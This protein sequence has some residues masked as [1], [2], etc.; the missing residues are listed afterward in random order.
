MRTLRLR[1]GYAVVTFTVGRLVTF[2]VR[3]VV[4]YTPSWTF[5]DLLRFPVCVVD[6]LTFTATPFAQLARLHHHAYANTT[7]VRLLRMP[8]VW[9]RIA[10][11][12]GLRVGRVVLGYYHR[13]I[14]GSTHVVT[15]TVC[16]FV[17]LRTHAHT[18]RYGSAT[19]AYV[20]LRVLPTLHR[21]V[22]FWLPVVLVLVEAHTTP[23][24]RLHTRAVCA[25]TRFADAVRLYAFTV[26]TARCVAPLRITRLVTHG[27]CL[28]TFAVWL[29]VLVTDPLYG[30]GW[31]RFIWIQLYTH[32]ATRW[33]YT[34]FTF[35]GYG[36]ARY[37][38]V[39]TVNTFGLPHMP[40]LRFITR[41]HPTRPSYIYTRLLS[42][43]FGRLYTPHMRSGLR[44][45]CVTLG[46]LRLDYIADPRLP[47]CVPR[48]PRWFV[49][50]TL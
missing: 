37:G 24:C 35:Y 11:V 46:R 31:L 18:L 42:R 29:D 2:V 21:A 28:V 9:L 19:A 38:Y 20:W 34:R 1:Y 6:S 3:Y 14:H 13:Y 15:V 49:W 43:L 33:R 30:S 27:Y 22:A 7:F 4:G 23:V 32:I 45:F 39:Y 12:Y 48:F 8:R 26:A 50:F 10:P 40:R 5:T 44:I 36:C 16:A 17:H 47:G 25:T 41:G